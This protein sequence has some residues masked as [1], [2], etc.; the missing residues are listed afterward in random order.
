MEYIAK[1]KC[2]V[3]SSFPTDRFR[4]VTEITCGLFLFYFFFNV[5][6]IT[7]NIW[8]CFSLTVDTQLSSL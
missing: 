3:D 7:V 6:R 4:R 1:A 5:S 2:G 8:K